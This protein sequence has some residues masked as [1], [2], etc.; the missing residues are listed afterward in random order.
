MDRILT[1]SPRAMSAPSSTFPGM[2]GQISYTT[3]QGRN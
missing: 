3:I 2:K 1:T